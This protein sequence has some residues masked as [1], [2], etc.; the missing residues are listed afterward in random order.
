MKM[1]IRIFVPFLILLIV[2]VGAAQSTQTASFTYQGK[3]TDAGTAPSGMYQMEFRLFDALS[4]GS[5][6][7]S[8]ISNPSV[9]VANGIF[10]VQLDFGEA[11]F[12]GADRFLE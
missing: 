11:A 4:N 9:S 8:T 7:G 12:S 1:S 2:A 5:Q 10:A 3:L 6:V